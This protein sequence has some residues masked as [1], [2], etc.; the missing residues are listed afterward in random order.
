[1]DVRPLNG[2][3]IL[4]GSEPLEDDFWCSSPCDHVL[5]PF[6]VKKHNPFGAVSSPRIGTPTDTPPA[7]DATAMN[8]RGQFG[9]ADRGVE[10]WEKARVFIPAARVSAVLCHDQGLW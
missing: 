9:Q 4:A 1:M 7:V 6:L 5:H 2:V 3:F 8:H 10:P